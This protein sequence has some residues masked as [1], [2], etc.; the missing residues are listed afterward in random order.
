MKPDKRSMRK[1]WEFDL[2]RLV[3]SVNVAVR[4]NGLNPKEH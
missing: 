3:A 1:P 2:K 4:E